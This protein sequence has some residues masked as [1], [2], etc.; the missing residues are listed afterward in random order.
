VTTEPAHPTTPPV[1]WLA[2]SSD[3]KPGRDASWVE[4]ML[5]SLAPWT[6][7]PVGILAGAAT[8][9]RRGGRVAALAALN[10]IDPDRYARTRNHLAGAITR[11]SPWLRH[12]VLSTAEVRD[13]ACRLVEQPQQAEKLIS[14]LAWRDYWQQVYASLGEAID[15]DLEPPAATS[16]RPQ[17]S[18]VPDDVL[19]ASTGMACVDAWVRELHSTGFLHNHVRMWLASWLV[20]ARGVRWQA[21]A[22]W[23][24]SQLLD[25]DPASNTLSWQWVAG[26]F[27]AKP[28]IFNRDNLERY[29]EGRWCQT[30]P[31]AGGCDLEGSYE[32]LTAAWFST[33]ARERP[34]CRIAP[35]KPWQPGSPGASGSAEPV[36]WITLD[37]LAETSPAAAAH[38]QAPRVCV[39]DPEWL[40]RERPSRLRLQFILECL[41]EIS[42]LDLAVGP[43]QLAL[44]E[45][46]ADRRGSGIVMNDTVCPVT[47][48]QAASLAAEHPLMVL[49]AAALADRARVN[50]LG[51]FSRYWSKIRRSAM[52]PGDAAG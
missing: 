7:P 36:V 49:P 51:R 25:A 29:S 22:A 42:H 35:A 26:T 17:L 13:T 34:R 16:R 41:A 38:P 44:S 15:S 23:F 32:D 11:L 31:L 2:R 47:R 48:Q 6:P 43:P 4:R 50:D 33:P 46:I 19:S 27:S 28:Y 3:C 30:C 21:G 18:E 5:E 12:G 9:I 52:Q 10:E 45:A 40:A 1:V 14:E 24:L 8:P 39:I 37:A 20:H